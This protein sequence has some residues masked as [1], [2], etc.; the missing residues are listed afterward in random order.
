MKEPSKSA[1]DLSTDGEHLSFQHPGVVL[2]KKQPS[3]QIP[4]IAY[5]YGGSTKYV[6]RPAVQAGFIYKARPDPYKAYQSIQPQMQPSYNS[7]KYQPFH[8]HHHSHIAPKSISMT[9]NS[10]TPF[11]PA[12]K[13]PGEFVPIFKSKN[14]PYKTYYD[15]KVT[16]QADDVRRVTSFPLDSFRHTAP[17]RKKKK[18]L[19][20]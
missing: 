2:R 11:M 5:L 4:S 6:Q 17:R 14:L 10:F 13:L 15:E 16:S 3:Q 19:H 20:Y 18:H 9:D 7:Y 8:H 1:R 12:N